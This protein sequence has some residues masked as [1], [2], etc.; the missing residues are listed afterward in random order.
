MKVVNT[1]QKKKYK[2]GGVSSNSSNHVKPKSNQKRSRTDPLG[3]NDKI[4]KEFDRGGPQG[5][6]GVNNQAFL[7]EKYP[8]HQYN[9]FGTRDSRKNSSTHGTA[10]QNNDNVTP[11]SLV[12]NKNLLNSLK[13]NKDITDFNL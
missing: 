1:G 3:G 12:L 7:M 6:T 11:S 5:P 13:A 2:D 4:S 8:G 9:P 10:V